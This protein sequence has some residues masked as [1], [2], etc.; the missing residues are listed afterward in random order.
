MENNKISSLEVGALSTFIYKAFILIGGINLLLS[1]NKNDIIIS[2]IIGFIVGFIIIF[3]FLHLNNILPKYNIFQKTDF[4]LPKFLSFIIKMVLTTCVFIFT[5]YALYNIS[6]F[7]QNAIL[8]NVDIL[9]IS[10]LLI[11]NIAYLSSKVIKTLTKTSLI[12]LFIF[13]IFEIISVL[14]ALTNISST[15]ILPIIQSDFYKTIYSS[16]NYTTLSF[17]PLFTL[18]VIPKNS[19]KQ[20]SKHNK[21]TKM[22]FIAPT[23]I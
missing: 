13:G 3:L 18:L 14:F 6:L 20:N 11:I 1:I 21:I 10:I 8:N 2:S 23:Y 9:P 12:C 19:I 4:V 7:I 16:F 22:F 15:K 5:S 17:I